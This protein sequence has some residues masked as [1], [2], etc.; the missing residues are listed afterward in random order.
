M[1]IFIFAFGA[2]GYGVVEVLFRGYTHWTMM[3][4]GGACFLT[5]YYLNQ[6]FE[7]TPI[8]MKAMIGAIIITIYEFSVGLI[9]NLWYGWRVWDYSHMPFNFY[10]QICPLFTV[11][12]F[13][14]CCGLL[15]I[16]KGIRYG[17][18]IFRSQ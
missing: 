4:T 11:L 13:F 12:W 3:L 2:V 17:Y 8:L 6:A 9:V 16:F 10:G 1:S 5:L 14:L 7:K 15:I 18:Q